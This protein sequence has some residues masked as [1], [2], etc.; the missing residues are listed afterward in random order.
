MHSG[1]HSHA[2]ATAW[3]LLSAIVFS[4]AGTAQTYPAK[5]VRMVIPIAPGG[6]TDI[7]GRMVAQKLTEA[8]GQQF[9]VDN[10]PGAGGRTRAVNRVPA[11]GM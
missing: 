7:V 8:L 10:R 4:T 3:V 2:V 6:G 11:C 5:P 9:I 1:N